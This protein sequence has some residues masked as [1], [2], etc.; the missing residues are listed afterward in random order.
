MTTIYLVVL[1]DRHTDDNYA[2]CRDLEQ[3]KRKADELMACYGTRYEWR[4]DEIDGWHYRHTTEIEDGPN[5]H[6]EEIDLV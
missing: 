3:A 2:A 5:I 4:E 1:Y 6:I